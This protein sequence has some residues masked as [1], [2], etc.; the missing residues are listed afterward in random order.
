[1]TLEQIQERVVDEIRIEMMRMQSNYDM[2]ETPDY[3][4]DELCDIIAQKFTEVWNEAI[5]ECEGKFRKRMYEV[6]ETNA[7]L[8]DDEHEDLVLYLADIPPAIELALLPRA[9]I[10]SDK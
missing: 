2:Q 7:W 3:Y 9:N 6:C 5:K 8:Y 1:M 4:D 10:T